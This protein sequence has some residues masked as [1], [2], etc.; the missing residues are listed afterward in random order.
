[1]SNFTHIL[2]SLLYPNPKQTVD[3]YTRVSSY[4]ELIKMYDNIQLN[5]QY[6]RYEACFLYYKL[7]GMFVKNPS[8]KEIFINEASEKEITLYAVSCI[9]VFY[10]SYGVMSHKDTPL[11]VPISYTVLIKEKLEQFFKKGYIV[12][13]SPEA[14]ES[15]LQS[16]NNL[17][18]MYVSMGEVVL[19]SK[20][21]SNVNAMNFIDKDTLDAEYEL[22]M[23]NL[24][25]LIALMINEEIYKVGS[26]I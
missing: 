21:M 16:I 17:I 15:S 8:F 13:N 6:S 3:G 7:D 5:P 2:M 14:F 25:C 23:I 1:M 20:I 9:Q 4:D 24:V 26:Y 10:I 22:H 12:G 11:E 19:L 18:S